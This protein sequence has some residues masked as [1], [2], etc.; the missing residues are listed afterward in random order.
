MRQ[1]DVEF[2]VNSGDN[3]GKKYGFTLATKD[4]EKQWAITPLFQPAPSIIKEK[5]VMALVAQEENIPLSG[6]K[7]LKAVG[8]ILEQLRSIALE[9]TP[10]TLMGFDKQKRLVQIDENGYSVSST[11][12]EP[13]R[14]PEYVINLSCWTI[15]DVT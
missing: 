12:L 7:E 1:Y 2:Q 9:T 4:G 15:Y 3:K 13:N 11:V 5:I 6:A 14:E 10:S 8:K